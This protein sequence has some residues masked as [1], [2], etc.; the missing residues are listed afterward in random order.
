[1][2]YWFLFKIFDIIIHKLNLLLCLDIKI[3]KICFVILYLKDKCSIVF[4]DRNEIADMLWL[5]L[6]ILDTFE[7]KEVVVYGKFF[8]IPNIRIYVFNNY[9]R[10]LI[11]YYIH[12]VD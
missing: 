12:N 10:S 8:T 1:M 4:Q 7:S 5:P 9:K 2:F 11:V 6:S 3:A